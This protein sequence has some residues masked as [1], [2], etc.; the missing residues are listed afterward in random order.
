MQGQLSQ[1]ETGKIGAAGKGS[2]LSNKDKPYK[3]PK[4]GQ[5]SQ[6]ETDKIGAAE[7]G[8]FLS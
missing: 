1:N 8:S 2:F 4:Q 5:L 6:N 3:F 7:K